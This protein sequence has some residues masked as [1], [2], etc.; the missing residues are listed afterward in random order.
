MSDDEMKV[1]TNYLRLDRED[2]QDRRAIAVLDLEDQIK[3]LKT[4]KSEVEEQ[5]KSV[6]EELKSLKNERDRILRFSDINPNIDDNDGNRL[7]NQDDRIRIIK[8]MSNDMEKFQFEKYTKNI[9]SLFW[10]YDN[11]KFVY[12]ESGLEC[13][14]WFVK[15]Y[16]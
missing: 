10:H 6:K 7:I 9:E 3:S 5:L 12:R 2:L 1:E 11:I 13:P 8:D 15:K 14:Q 16:R 4:K